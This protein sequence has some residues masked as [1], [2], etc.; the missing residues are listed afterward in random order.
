MKSKRTTSTLYLTTLNKALLTSFKKAKPSITAAISLFNKRNNQNCFFYKKYIEYWARRDEDEREESGCRIEKRIYSTLEDVAVNVL[1]SITQA[2]KRSCNTGESSSGGSSN[3]DSN[4]NDNDNDSNSNNNVDKD[5]IILNDLTSTYK[6]IT[7]LQIL[8]LDD[9]GVQSILEKELLETLIQQ[10]SIQV[11]PMSPQAALILHGLNGSTAQFEELRK[12]IRN[13]KISDSIMTYPD[14]NFIET[15]GN[16]FL[17]LCQSPLNPLLMPTL[18]R[19]TAAKTAVIL[20]DNLFLSVNDKIHFCWFEVETLLTRS[21][22]WDGVGF[23]VNADKRIGYCLVEFS[24]GI[25][26]NCSG[27]KAGRDEE[28][29]ETGVVMF[30]DFTN[31]DK[32]HFIRFHDMKLY[33]ESVF[34]L[35]DR[36]IRR[37]HA[38][39]KLPTTPAEMKDFFNQTQ[40]LFSWKKSLIDSLSL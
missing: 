7:G 14:L 22:K 12:M 24:G 19:T 30:M 17:N 29:I 39:I 10:T 13:F 23:H 3:N 2:S 38:T 27:K 36:L 40:L 33:F 8:F 9:N 28:K 21:T 11:E 20:L 4:N 1:S 35:E 31:A 15:M 25:K 6:E 37:T 5:S 32:G 26:K 34:K 18:E 16:H